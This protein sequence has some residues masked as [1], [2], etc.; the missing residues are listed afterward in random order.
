MDI[1]C[2]IEALFKRRGATLY[3]GNQLARR[4]PVTAV[5]HAL[6]CAQLAEWAHADTTL[7][8]AALLH[9]LGQL[10]GGAPDEGLCNDQHERSAL[11]FLAGGGFGPSVLE[12]IRLHVE[13]KRYLVATDEGYG[14]NL[15]LASRHSL[16][17][18][19]GPMSIEERFAFLSQPFASRALQLRRW[20][21]LAKHPGKRTPPLAYYLD[22]LDDVLRDSK[23]PARVAVA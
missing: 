4:E 2:K 16:A 19:G 10:M 6:Q 14:D 5:A 12:P 21:D 18:Q 23:Q 3:N 17:L 7:V 1:V 13:A 8:A 15:T 20:D 11:T 22:V 9:D